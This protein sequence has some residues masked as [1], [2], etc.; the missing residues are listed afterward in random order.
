MIINVEWVLQATILTA[1]ICGP[2]IIYAW[3]LTSGLD[4]RQ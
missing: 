4:N 1:M 3:A 2:A